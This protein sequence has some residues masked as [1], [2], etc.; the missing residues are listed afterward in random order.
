MT[1][2]KEIIVCASGNGI[3]RFFKIV[4]GIFRPITVNLRREQQNYVVQSWL[5]NESVILGTESNELIV[6]HNFVTKV[7]VPINNG[8]DQ[9]ITSMIPFSQGVIVGG[10]KGSI[11]VYTCTK[12][13]DFT[14]ILAKDMHIDDTYKSEII[15]IDKAATEEMF[16]CLLSTGRICSFPLSDNEIPIGKNMVPWFHA[17][18]P[19]GS[20]RITCMDICIL[21]PIVATG[22]A[23]KTLRIWNYETKDFELTS[24]FDSSIITISLHPSSLQILICFENHVELDYI[25][26]KGLSTVWRRDI[27]P[28]GSS[29]FSNGGQYF[30][31]VCGPLAQVY[32]TY[33]FD[34]ICTLRGHSSPVEAI[35][36]KHNDQELATIG[37]DGVVRVW[38]VS[39]GKRKLRHGKFICILKS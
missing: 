39:N 30:A 4:D 20:C 9:S 19:D 10:N 28:H 1:E 34:P 8:W 22:G 2:S 24:H 13:N 3:I 11:R 16:I 7:V 15:A 32:G 5:S 26:Y 29:C 12:E 37:S 27:Q 33:K 36:W 38:T 14:P 17:A 21:K 6:M 25:Q 35:A 31:L 23:D 18:G